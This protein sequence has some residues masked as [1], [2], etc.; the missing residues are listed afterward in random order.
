MKGNVPPRLPDD[1]ETEAA[2]AQTGIGV[3]TPLGRPL[4]QIN[5]HTA[6]FCEALADQPSSA[7]DPA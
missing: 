4:R 6:L 1:A 5:T 7:T 3:L 2:S